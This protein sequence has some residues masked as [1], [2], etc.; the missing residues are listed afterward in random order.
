MMEEKLFSG[1][2]KS[3]EE[4][5]DNRQRFI[6]A[7]PDSAMFQNEWFVLHLAI[8][9]FPGTSLSANFIKQWL[10]TNKAEFSANKHIN[11]ADMSFGDSDPYATFADTVLAAYTNCVN[12]PCTPDE[13][14]EALELYRMDYVT[15]HSIDV[16]EQGVSI[17]DG[18]LQVSGNRSLAGF[19][20][21][22]GYVQNELSRLGNMLQHNARKGIIVYDAEPEEDEDANN[23]ICDYGIKPLDDAI[24]GI[25]EGDMISLLAPP[26]GGKS[27]MSVCLIHHALMCGVSVVVW[28]IENGK[29]GVESLI[30]ARHFDYLYNRGANS[31]HKSI[32][33]RDI[34]NK[35]L[36]EE[37][38][39]LE[40]ASWTDLKTNPKY[41]RLVNID[42]DFD[43]DTFL[44]ILGNAVD[45]VGAKIVLV[46]YLQLITGDGKLSKNERISQCYQ[47]SLQFLQSKKIAGIFPAQIKQSVVG[48]LGKCSNEQ[49]RNVELRDAGGESSEVIRTPSVLFLLY[50]TTQMIQE[51]NLK[52]IS[53]PSR[54][55]KPFDPIDL[56]AD[57][58]TCYF[59]YIAGEK[60]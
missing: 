28:S 46:D 52:L 43:A 21:M 17:L 19:D 58:A 29:K 54:N 36:D 6:A 39:K 24:G 10:R 11:L 40:A 15:S 59:D 2:F 7:F 55:A 20:D 13:F 48:D 31:K 32:D 23:V 47:R 1:L 26:K 3:L 22:R 16:L 57:F 41:G 42:E 51:N 5:R 45:L 53:I 25:T 56:Y 60:D 14:N 12:T 30:R 27:R 44:S 9:R 38:A 18:G 37:T 49:L 35:S 4:S 8:K 50:G 34:K 33:A